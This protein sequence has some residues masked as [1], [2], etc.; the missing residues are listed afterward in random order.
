M[1]NFSIGRTVTYTIYFYIID[2]DSS[3]ANKLDYS[4]NKNSNHNIDIFQSK[5]EFLQQYSNQ[6]LKVG[7]D[8]INIILIDAH[9]LEPE[10]DIKLLRKLKKKNKNTEF[11]V[12]TDG[13]SNKISS[14]ALDLGVYEI[15]QKN[16]NIFYRIENSIKSVT[17]L[18]N[19]LKKKKSLRQIV[20]ALIIFVALSG[21]LFYFLVLIQN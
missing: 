18:Y 17:S 13:V 15:I 16:D 11:I 9:Q 10:K 21:T 12:L 5:K 7:R 20:Y 8:I 19:F 3:C 14:F 1:R 4:L 2:S 6:K